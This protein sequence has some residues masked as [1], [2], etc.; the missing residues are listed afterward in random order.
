MLGQTK[1]QN[2]LSKECQEGTPPLFMMADFLGVRPESFPI[3]LSMGGS[4]M[5]LKHLPYGIAESSGPTYTHWA[6]FGPPN[7]HQCDCRV[8]GILDPSFFGCF[9]GWQYDMT[10][11]QLYRPRR[12]S[13]I[14]LSLDTS[15]RQCGAGRPPGFEQL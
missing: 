11:P 8:L 12:L 2:N 10:V 3:P 1:W 14:P 9:T 5:L 7:G 4:R 6:W 15:T 13:A